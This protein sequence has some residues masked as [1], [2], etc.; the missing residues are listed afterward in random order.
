MLG[1][2]LLQSSEAFG[3]LRG[4]VHG[5]QGIKAI[6]TQDAGF[7]LRQPAIH[8]CLAA[9]LRDP[10]RAAVADKFRVVPTPGGVRVQYHSPNRLAGLYVSLV[11]S[12]A[13]E[14]GEA[15]VVRFTAGH[16]EG[17]SCTMEVLMGA[18]VPQVPAS[19]MADA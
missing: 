5:I 10:Q 12:L 19:E 11:H 14:Y 16:V 18:A 2:A 1:L 15:A 4:Q 17:V 6:V 3:K 9:G 13:L 7:L 8:N